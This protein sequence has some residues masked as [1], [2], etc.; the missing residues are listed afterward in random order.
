MEKYR[1]FYNKRGETHAIQFDINWL[2]KLLLDLDKSFQLGELPKLTSKNGIAYSEVKLE[3]DGLTLRLF[4]GNEKKVLPSGYVPK[5]SDTYVFGNWDGIEWR[6]S[7][8]DSKFG[9]GRYV[10]L[11]RYYNPQ[12][13]NYSIVR[14]YKKS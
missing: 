8:I 5:K 3:N 6:S 4:E 12:Y 9:T 1:K 10:T 13:G 14:E 11:K 2:R 7:I